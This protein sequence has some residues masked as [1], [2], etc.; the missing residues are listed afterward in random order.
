MTFIF[1]LH[2]KFYPRSINLLTH[3]RAD[4]HTPHTKRRRVL[5][6]ESVSDHRPT[7]CAAPACRLISTLK[8]VS[9]S[10]FIC[11]TA[12]S[13]VSCFEATCFLLQNPRCF[14]TWKLSFSSRM[15]WDRFN[16]TIQRTINI[17][18]IVVKKI[19][20]AS[21]MCSKVYIRSY[22]KVNTFTGIWQKVDLI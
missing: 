18:A 14:Q 12:G 16:V 13:G 8:A 7:S 19:L 17:N 6:R 20:S 5:R 9:N 1:A 3:T 11:I 10:G 21:F 4:T 2:L 22:V 15:T